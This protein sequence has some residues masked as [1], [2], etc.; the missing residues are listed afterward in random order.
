MEGSLKAMPRSSSCTVADSERC[1]STSLRR[2]FL[3]K[4]FSSSGSAGSSGASAAT[5][6][7][8]SP[9]D[10]PANGM[11]AWF[12][13]ENAGSVWLSSVGNIE[14]YSTQYH[15]NRKVASGFGADRPVTYIE[16]PWK[17]SKFRFGQPGE[18]LKPTF[19]ICSVTRYTGS[20]RG[21]ILQTDKVNWLHGHWADNSGV[22]YYQ[23]WIKGAGTTNTWD[24]VVLCGTN[25]GGTKLYEL[26]GSP[27][28]PT[29]VATG[30]GQSHPADSTLW[31]GHGYDSGT[32]A[33][34]SDFA[35]MEVI[36]WDRA[37]SDDEMKSSVNYLKWKLRVGAVL[38]VSEHLATEGQKNF[39]SYAQQSLTDIAS[40]TYDVPLANN[41]RADV[42]G[43]THTRDYARG[44]LRNTDGK[45]TAVVKS[46]TPAAKYIYQ[47]YMVHEVPSWEGQAKVSV[48]H[49]HNCHVWQG[50]MNWP[51]LSGVAQANPRGEINFEFERIS[52]HIHLS[53]IAIAKVGG[54]QV[55]KPADPPANGMVAWFKSEN[56]GSVWLS[57]VGNIEAYSTQYHVNRKVASGFGADR[58]V[59]YIESPWKSSKFRFGQPGEVLKPTFTICSVTRY[60]GSTRGRILQTDKVNWLH[61]H[62]AD[63]S[64]VAYYQGWI[65]GAGTTNTWDWVV[66]CG[67][68]GGGTKLYEL[69][70]SP[71]QPTSVA[72]GQ[73]QSHPADSTLW[74]GHGYDSG[75][76]A[77]VSD[78]AVME[79][80]TWDRA[81]SDDEMK[82]SVNY[83]KWKL[84][85]G[86][87]LEVS[88]H[89]ATEG[90]KNFDSYAQQ[91]LTDIASNTYDVPLANNYRADVSGW[92]HTRDYARGFLRNTDGKATA[93]VK[94]LT[95]AAK[96]IYQVYMVHEVP[97]WEGQAKVSVN[98]GHNCHVWQGSM[99]WPVLSGV[100]QANPRGEINFEF[101]RISHHIHLSGIAIAKVGGAVAAVQELVDLQLDLSRSSYGV[102]AG[103]ED[104]ETKI[105][106]RPVSSKS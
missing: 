82:A 2:S 96:Y 80:I 60:T 40:N 39:D 38:E 22:A 37:L 66:L 18:V 92:T 23:G 48:N 30:Q 101:E 1:W 9:G 75:T 105:R 8:A 7:P 42:S 64:G 100:A 72:T 51:V 79:V 32:T 57:S 14:A 77:E 26:Q 87:V 20:T 10:P 47:V 45:A 61:G 25:G 55:Q 74:V 69:Q 58:P 11:V 35:V 73:G 88:E 83:L 97:S 103:I 91:S 67:T 62:W 24:W 34:V 102:L 15:V 50:S 95:P 86:A 104:D 21:R 4:A 85:V 28:Q 31:V 19:T 13:S 43:W 33:E 36:T 46:L 12:K 5:N 70:G 89:L 3:T 106:K 65:K 52:H 29:S 27:G 6:L 68:N 94:G 78:F 71:G 56:A 44:F 59:T 53:G 63:N 54:V 41:Y 49:G 81:L 16:S 98:H 17:S 90:Q 76:T 84:R 99:N 93:V